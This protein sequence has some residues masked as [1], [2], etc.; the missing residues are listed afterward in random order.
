MS[1]MVWKHLASSNRSWMFTIGGRSVAG[2]SGS[3][4]PTYHPTQGADCT[5]SRSPLRTT[6]PESIMSLEGYH[7]I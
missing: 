3:V 6:T 1:R 4:E 7:T 2:R 5:D